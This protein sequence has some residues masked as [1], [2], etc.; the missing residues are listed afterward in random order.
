[1]II[2]GEPV[3]ITVTEYDPAWPQRFEEEARLIRGILGDELAGLFHIGST[4]VEGLAA[5]PV[6][7]ILPVV[8]DIGRVDLHNAEF[9]SLG[10]E[11]MGEFGIP[12]RRYFRKGGNDRTHNIHAFQYDDASNILRH[13]AFRD[14]LRTHPEV[15][16]AYGALKAELALRF[17]DDIDGYCDGKDEFVKTHER[18]ALLW[19]WGRWQEDGT[20]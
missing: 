13:L 14:Y 1:M 19:Y 15:R 4:A 8:L 7:D 16:A 20:L 3:K 5:K 11:C 2:K 12:G 17:P 9:E 18:N 6:I 10:Y